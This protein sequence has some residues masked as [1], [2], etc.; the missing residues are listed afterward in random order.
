M[1]AV[2]TNKPAPPLALTGN[3]QIR[4]L[5]NEHKADVL[6][7]LA[8]RPSHTF[9]M[10]SWIRDNGLA[11]SLNR[12]TFYGY[13]DANGR[14]EGVAL[15]G[16]IT[17]FEAEADS[18]LAAFAKLTQNCSSARTVLS[19]KS[20]ISQ[21][22]SYYTKESAQPRLVCLLVR[23]VFLVAISSLFPRCEPKSP[24]TQNLWTAAGSAST[25][26]RIR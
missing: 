20:K 14:L 8:A 12:G 17:L 18:A 23:W 6:S 1:L 16:H 26:P 15:I 24:R 2:S 21:F 13:R 10:S 5:D 4:P 7:F 11:S 9:I 3:Q 22:M 25:Q 19:E